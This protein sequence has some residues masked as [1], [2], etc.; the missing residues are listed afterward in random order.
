MR[1]LLDT[2][3]FLWWCMDDEAVPPRIRTLV[4]DPA[5]EVWLSAVSAWEIMLK[6]ALG[7]LPLPQPPESFFPEA[8]E[9]HGFSSLPLD[10]ASTRHLPRLPPHHRD[11]F[12]RILVCQGIEHGLRLVTPDP[13]I[14]RYPVSSVW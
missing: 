6:H 2:C 10:E 5:N 7:R 1:L 11:P 13:L 3:V 4:A 12:D 14:G 9:R 8:R